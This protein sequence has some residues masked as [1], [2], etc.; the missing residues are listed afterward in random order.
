MLV[1][2]V[3]EVDKI[4]FILFIFEVLV[5]LVLGIGIYLLQFEVKLYKSTYGQLK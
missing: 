1:W 4:K 5:D 3:Y 2:K